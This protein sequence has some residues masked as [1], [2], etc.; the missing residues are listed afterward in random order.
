MRRTLLGLLAVV[1]SACSSGPCPRE[2]CDAFEKP[3]V[4]TGETGVGGVVARESNDTTN[5][6]TECP[7][8]STR[9]ALW[10]TDNFM[11]VLLTAPPT[12]SVQANGRY[13]LAL[14]PGGYT[15]CVGDNC[16]DLTVSAN[17]VTSL[18]VRFGAFDTSKL[19]VVNR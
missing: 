12:A 14:E 17:H 8:G 16:V 18:N 2:G 13:F 9:I 19:D 4:D 3:A 10:A 6:C 11:N 1:C 15:A 7:F 5:G